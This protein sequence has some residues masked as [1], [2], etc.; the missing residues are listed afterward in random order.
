M[1]ALLARGESSSGASALTDGEEAMKLAS[2]I[3]IQNISYKDVRAKR[4]LIKALIAKLKAGSG[5]A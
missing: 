4:D 5:G 3:A 1:E 2:S